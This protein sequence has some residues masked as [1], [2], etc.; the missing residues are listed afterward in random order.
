MKHGFYYCWARHYQGNTIE[1]QG[2]LWLAMRK[3]TVVTK[4]LKIDFILYSCSFN[5]SKVR[6]VNKIFPRKVDL[7]A[8]V[9]VWS[10]GLLLVQDFAKKVGKLLGFSC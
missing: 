1:N 10:Y 4:K 2:Y 6:N 8:W 7:L 9:F 3:P 5:G